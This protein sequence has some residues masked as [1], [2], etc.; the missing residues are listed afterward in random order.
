MSSSSSS[1]VDSTLSKSVSELPGYQ[2]NVR[3]RDILDKDFSLTT[4]EPGDETDA[5]IER[6]WTCQPD[7][8]EEEGIPL[9][10]TLSYRMEDVH[11]GQNPFYQ[12]RQH[13]LSRDLMYWF[14]CLGQRIQIIVSRAECATMR[15]VD[16]IRFLPEI[17][18]MFIAACAAG[19]GQLKNLQPKEY[20][21]SSILEWRNMQHTVTVWPS[22]YCLPH[23]VETLQVQEMEL[24]VAPG[25]YHLCD[26]RSQ[27]SSLT[28][29]RVS[30]PFIDQSGSSLERIINATAGTLKDDIPS[31]DPLSGDGALPKCL[32]S[33]YVSTLRLIF[34]QN[35]SVW[36]D[37]WDHWS[38][39]VEDLTIGA[40][41][42]EQGTVPTLQQFQQLKTLCF[43]LNL[44]S[45]SLP[46]ILE[47]T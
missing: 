22:L 15:P 16:P 17:Q 40:N 2:I 21:L 7:L 6:W 28:L 18:H 8:L 27:L 11:S 44:V 14:M 34:I 47:V 19:H 13:A 33:S 42:E 20:W 12:I 29:D 46:W 4:V 35:F 26:N 10:R 37:I 24:Q 3:Y 39:S 30:V 45:D 23:T 5:L 36:E 25:L 43:E 32:D 1:D 9:T 31:H 38:E 41:G